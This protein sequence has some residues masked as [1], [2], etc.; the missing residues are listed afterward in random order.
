MAM[1]TR[2]ILKALAINYYVHE[3]KLYHKFAS[4]NGKAQPGTEA[5]WLD[6]YGY[7]IMEVSACRFPV[8]RAIYYLKT[9]QWC[10]YLDHIDGDPLNNSLDNLRPANHSNNMRNTRLSKRNTSGYK[11][12]SWDKKSKLWVVRVRV[13]SYYKVFGKFADKELAGLVASEV[14]RKYHGEFAKDG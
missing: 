6:R 11:G 2:A 5:G 13:A 8:H 14:R 1:P 4:R 3:N 9:G 7:R 10:V 12:V